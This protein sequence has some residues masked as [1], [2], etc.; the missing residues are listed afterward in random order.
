MNLKNTFSLFLKDRIQASKNLFKLNKLAFF[1][2]YFYL[3]FVSVF[4]IYF[5][6]NLYFSLIIIYFDFGNKCLIEKAGENLFELKE[7]WRIELGFINMN[8][9]F[10]NHIAL[11]MRR[12]GDV[13]VFLNYNRPLVYILM[14][15]LV[16]DFLRDPENWRRIIWFMVNNINFLLFRNIPCMLEYVYIFILIKFLFSLF[17][18]YLVNTKTY[19]NLKLK[20]NF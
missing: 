18:K 9:L 20:Y 11:G 12:Y 15:H 17:Q 5:L 19:I 2:A 1:I 7:S 13:W 14:N 3:I 8:Y 10:T 6:I 4:T 16:E